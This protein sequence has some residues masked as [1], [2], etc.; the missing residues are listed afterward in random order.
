M[1]IISGAIA[2]H[3]LRL[4]GVQ[5]PQEELKEIVASIHLERDAS[6]D[7]LFSRRYRFPVFLQSWSACF[8]SYG[9]STPSS[10]I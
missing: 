3:V 5:Q 4:T 6:A 8:V 1:T 2:L 9:G 10:T 7:H